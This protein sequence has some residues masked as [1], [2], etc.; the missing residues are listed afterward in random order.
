MTLVITFRTS[1][2][3]PSRDGCSDGV[4]GRDDGDGG[5]GS[6]DGDR[7]DGDGK[8]CNHKTWSVLGKVARTLLGMLS[9]LV[10]SAK[11]ENFLEYLLAL[12]TGLNKHK[13]VQCSAR[14]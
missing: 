1:A 11:I 13:S 5:C 2:S 12:F 9:R 8:P 10:H 3:Q 14:C 7:S 6:G 4:D